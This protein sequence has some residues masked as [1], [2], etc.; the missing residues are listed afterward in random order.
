MNIAG[1]SWT[2][3]SALARLGCR[4]SIPDTGPIIGNV[5]DRPALK[6][7]LQHLAHIVKGTDVGDAGV[8]GGINHVPHIT[9]V[10]KSSITAVLQP[11]ICSTVIF[12]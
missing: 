2:G 5:G 9:G 12:E 10:E 7:H 1:C 3:I 4:C 8:G 11:A 6:I